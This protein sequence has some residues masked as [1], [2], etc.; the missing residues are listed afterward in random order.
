MATLLRTEGVVEAARKAMLDCLE[1][2]FGHDAPSAAVAGTGM[3]EDQAAGGAAAAEEAMEELADE[4][5][6][7]AEVE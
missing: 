3:A 5:D 1:P 2:G 6:D 7:G 4:E